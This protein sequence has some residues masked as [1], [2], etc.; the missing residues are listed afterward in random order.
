MT[1]DINF[2]NLILCALLL[3]IPALV[4]MKLNLGINK[5]MLISVARMSVQLFIVG[6]VL[7]YLFD[8]SNPILTTAWMLV[9]I[10]FAAFTTI[11]NAGLKWKLFIYPIVV[12]YLLSVIPI[13]FYFN[14][15]VVMIN[16]LD[17]RFAI[18]II[19]MLLGNSIRGNVV[20]LNGFLKDVKR[21]RNRY[22]Y[23]LAMGATPFEASRDFFRKG[24]LNALKPTLASVATMGIVF[25][26]GMMTGQ[27]L[28]GLDPTS[29]I[30]Y[31][32]A[33][34][35]TIFSSTVASV[36]LTFW[37]V[38]KTAFDKWGILREDIFKGQ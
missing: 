5:E 35:I 22:L 13:L 34:M 38:K 26:P 27:I 21:N 6:L 12:S 15:I 23:R 2:L 3:I 7:A 16:V 33:I 18:A 11:R 37:M 19:G 30:R 24:L 10:T 28:A 25:L 4:S 9:M 31:Q 20:G 32:I 29:A 1:P 14:G 17:P 36:M 8:V